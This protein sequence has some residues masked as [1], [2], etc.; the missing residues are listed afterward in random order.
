MSAW[1][2]AA[3]TIVPRLGCSEACWF[4][5]LRRREQEIS[6][7]RGLLR[8]KDGPFHEVQAVHGVRS[9][10]MGDLHKVN[11]AASKQVNR[12]AL[13]KLYNP[14]AI[15]VGTFKVSVKPRGGM[16]DLWA[17]EIHQIVTGGDKA[18]LEKAFA[19]PRKGKFISNAVSV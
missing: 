12:R 5:T 4:G 13:D 18:S 3:P 2:T 8:A 6:A 11:I 10:A 9:C 17:C 7:V 19:S 14:A 1:T 15:A 16:V